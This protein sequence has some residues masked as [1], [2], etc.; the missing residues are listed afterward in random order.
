MGNAESS[1][2]DGTILGKRQHGSAGC[3]WLTPA[4]LPSKSKQ[5]WPGRGVKHKK[6]WG[7]LYL[8]S[9][10]CPEVDTVGH[11]LQAGDHSV[12]AVDENDQRPGGGY[13]GSTRWWPTR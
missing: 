1:I 12:G 11:G 3:W 4:G 6:L 13:G 9:E 10:K 2:F 7:K 5:R 8:I